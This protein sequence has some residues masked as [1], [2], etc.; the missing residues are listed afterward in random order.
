ML[1]SLTRAAVLGPPLEPVSHQVMGSWLSDGAKFGFHLMEQ[2]LHT[3][4]RWLVTPIMFM[5]LLHQWVCF[6]KQS[7][8]WLHDSQLVMINHFFPPVAREAPSSAVKG[9]L[10]LLLVEL[11]L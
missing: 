7:L 6:A 9:F 2:G 11:P 10:L 3:I 5:P 8:L 4:R 1:C